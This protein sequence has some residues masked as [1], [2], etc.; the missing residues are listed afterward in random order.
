MARSILSEGAIQRFPVHGE[1][2]L[3]GPL[4]IIVAVPFGEFL[5]QESKA[6]IPRA[7]LEESAFDKGVSQR[8]PGNVH[9]DKTYLDYTES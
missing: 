7:A 4:A 1:F 6:A 3:D 9:A 8:H 5:Q 2:L